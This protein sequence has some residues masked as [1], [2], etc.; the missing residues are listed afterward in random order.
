MIKQRGDHCGIAGDSIPNSGGRGRVP[1]VHLH[2]QTV[3]AYIDLDNSS[4]RYQTLSAGPG[5]WSL[6]TCLLNCDEHLSICH[7]SIRSSIYPLVCPSI[8]LSDHPSTH[9]SVCLSHPSI[10]SS[11]YPS[12]YPCLSI[13]PFVHPPIHPSIHPTTHLSIHLSIHPL[14]ICQ[15]ACPPILTLCSGSIT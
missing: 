10:Y 11:I 13:Y 8:H 4:Y 12:I 6:D 5:I 1:R 3:L 2:F 15:S 9:L 14:S 7:L